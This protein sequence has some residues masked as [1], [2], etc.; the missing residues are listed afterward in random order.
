[1][2]A[3]AQRVMSIAQALAAHWYETCCQIES[4]HNKGDVMEIFLGLLLVSISSL[5]DQ[6]PVGEQGK[7]VFIQDG[8]P[9]QA[10][11]ETALFQHLDRPPYLLYTLKPRFLQNVLRA[12]TFGS[13]SS[14]FI[15]G[16]V[17]SKGF[18]VSPFWCLIRPPTSTGS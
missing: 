17:N 5:A 3:A 9:A 11:I 8:P 12:T 1:M 10:Y 15:A 16:S 6:A 18:I 2:V 7:P 4:N 14:I 13:P